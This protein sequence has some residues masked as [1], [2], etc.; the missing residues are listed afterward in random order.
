[1]NNDNIEE[2]IMKK[3]T[4]YITLLIL[5]AAISGWAQEDIVDRL[6]VAFSNPDQP[7]IIDVGLHYGGITVTAYDGNEVLIEA[8]TRLKSLSE[9]DS[10]GQARGMRRIPVASTALTVEE[11]DNYMEIETESYKRTVDITLQV[12]VNTSLRLSCHHEGDIYVKGVRGVI[13]AENHHGAITLEDISGAA[14]AETHH[15]DISV[16]FIAI[17]SDEAMSFETYHGDIDISFPSSVK[18]N[19]KLNSER[20]EVYSDFDIAKSPNPQ[21]IVEENGR[22]RGGKY[23]ICIEHAFFGTINGGGQDMSFKTYHG[24]IYIHE[25]K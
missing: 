1:M 21:N 25:T 12:P 24:N 22:S 8:R 23:K 17:D 3:V 6:N 9:L 16:Q 5:T 20:G 18:A 7:G 10:E 2:R 14:R 11:D 13:E 15:K 4:L 19:V